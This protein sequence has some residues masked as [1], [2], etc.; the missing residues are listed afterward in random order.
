MNP[1]P[2]RL[3]VGR[4]EAGLA[5]SHRRRSAAP[6]S[7]AASKRNASPASCSALRVRSSAS[8]SARSRWSRSNTNSSPAARTSK[9]HP[10]P[11]PARRRPPAPRRGTAPAA[12]P[13]PSRTNWT[14]RAHVRPRVASR[15]TVLLRPS[16]PYAASSSA[17]SRARAMGGASVGSLRAVRRAVMTSGCVM[18]PS[19][20]RRPPHGHASTSSK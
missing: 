13:A 11:P 7:L 1:S 3:R 15:R 16:A 14:T 5:Q 12:L 4:Q 9:A 18:S 8:R 2:S 17:G 6:R 10:A 20:R 19:T